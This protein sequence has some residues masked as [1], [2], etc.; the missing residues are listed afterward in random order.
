[1]TTITL[2]SKHVAE[3][4][5]SQIILLVKTIQVESNTSFEDALETGRD[6]L[7]KKHTELMDEENKQNIIKVANN[8]KEKYIKNPEDDSLK[9]MYLLCK[10]FGLYKYLS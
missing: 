9:E 8:I 4:L 2:N 1:M 3:S 6:Y 7:C 10:Y 5:E